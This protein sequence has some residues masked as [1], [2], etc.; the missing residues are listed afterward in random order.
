MQF[1][2]HMLDFV[3]LANFY[4]KFDYFSKQF[5]V[6]FVVVFQ[7]ETHTWKFFGKANQMNRTEM[8]NLVQA[9]NSIIVIQSDMVH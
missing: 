1:Q 3:Q 9:C 7:F 5:F 2:V 8:D 6:K 4:E